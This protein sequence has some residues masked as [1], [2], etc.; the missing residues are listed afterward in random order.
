VARRLDAGLTLSCHVVHVDQEGPQLGIRIKILSLAP[1]DTPDAAAPADMERPLCRTLG[2]PYQANAL[3][4][5][6][7]NARRGFGAGKG[8]VGYRNLDDALNWALD[9]WALRH[10]EQTGRPVGWVN[11]FHDFMQGWTDPLRRR[12]GLLTLVMHCLLDEAPPVADPAVPDNDWRLSVALTLA[13]WKRRHL[14]DPAPALGA[15]P[16]TRPIDRLDWAFLSEI[17]AVTAILSSD[18]AV[19]A[20]TPRAERLPAARREQVLR[21]LFRWLRLM[22][23]HERCGLIPV[24]RMMVVRALSWDTALTI[25]L[26]V[27]ALREALECIPRNPHE[28]TQRREAEL[29]WPDLFPPPPVPYAELRRLIEY[30]IELMETETGSADEL[31]ALAEHLRRLQ[32]HSRRCHRRRVRTAGNTDLY[33]VECFARNAA[34]RT[35]DPYATI[36]L[37]TVCVPYRRLN[38]LRLH[39]LERIADLLSQRYFG[40]SH[41]M[42]RNALPPPAFAQSRCPSDAV[43]L[44]R[45]N[46]PIV[47]PW[48][49]P[50]AL[51]GYWSAFVHWVTVVPVAWSDP[52]NRESYRQGLHLRT[53][54]REQVLLWPRRVARRVSLAL[55]TADFDFLSSAQPSPHVWGEAWEQ[56]Y[57]HCPATHWWYYR[58]PVGYQVEVN[59]LA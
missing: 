46:G 48:V 50:H 12:V 4:N 15:G 17:S 2:P 20:P 40:V 49:T 23:D 43:W 31:Y 29:K 45:D 19:C 38:R 30:A 34:A 7:A 18:P 56:A 9:L 37:L 3:A 39:D 41:Q 6:L 11:L 5:A 59:G 52:L 57:G 24:S 55:D 16:G 53:Q 21:C 33:L 51:A 47:P 26:Q 42:L 54:V 13:A 22:D 1:G 32:P 10:P 36:R 58:V 8:L 44:W 35:P 28:E 14:G 27:A 25:G